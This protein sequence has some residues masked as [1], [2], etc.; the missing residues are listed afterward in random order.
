MRISD[1]SSDVCSS[2]LVG[3]RVR[4]SI[5]ILR[6]IAVNV[7]VSSGIGIA[8]T[9]I[10]GIMVP[11][12]IGGQDGVVLSARQLIPVGIL[13]GIIRM[14]IA[15]GALQCSFERRAAARTRPLKPGEEIRSE[16]RRVGKGGVS[17]CK[18]RWGPKP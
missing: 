1:W 17:T 2:D 13:P 8:H 15:R 3:K 18:L 10:T 5:R 6:S 9:R 7:G 14:E 16:E 11:V 12:A 4:I